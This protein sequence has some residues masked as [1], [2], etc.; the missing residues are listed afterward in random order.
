LAAAESRS[1]AVLPGT[2][3]ALT[4]L[5]LG[6][7]FYIQEGDTL[8]SS[9]LQL[10]ARDAAASCLLPLTGLQKLNLDEPLVSELGNS[11]HWHWLLDNVQLAC[12]LSRKT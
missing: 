9:L 6:S 10:S 11:C 12:L 2:F 4:Q 3:A 7:R 8:P 1:P 5:D